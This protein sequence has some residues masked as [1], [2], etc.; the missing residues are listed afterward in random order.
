M[1]T[2]IVREREDAFARAKH[3]GVPEINADDAVAAE[4]EL[5]KR[6]HERI[7]ANEQAGGRSPGFLTHILTVDDAPGLTTPLEEAYRRV[8]VL[9]VGTAKSGLL[10]VRVSAAHV[11]DAAGARATEWL[12]E[13]LPPLNTPDEEYRAVLS[14][15]LD[16]IA[17]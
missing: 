10:W 9:V 6:L 12:E 3:G 15:D 1:G 8:A 13:Q 11:G 17:T 16:R 4:A 2:D 7:H 14:L 5:R